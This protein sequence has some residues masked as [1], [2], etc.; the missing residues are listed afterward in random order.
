MSTRMFL[1]ETGMN[2]KHLEVLSTILGIPSIGDYRLDRCDYYT[3]VENLKISASE[4]RRLRVLL[5]SE[6]I[7]VWLI[8]VRNNYH[9][10]HV[11][12]SYIDP[13]RPKNNGI[14]KLQK[15]IEIF[16]KRRTLGG[17]KQEAE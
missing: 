12:Y 13:D 15:C 4:G 5:E 3:L 7:R 16:H 6:G 11:E 1:V 14:R 17:S 2:G 8:E 10:G 9:G